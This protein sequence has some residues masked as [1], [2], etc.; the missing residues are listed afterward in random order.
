MGAFIHS[1]LAPSE[2]LGCHASRLCHHPACVVR[3][4]AHLRVLSP[5]AVGP[6][7]IRSRDPSANVTALSKP[8]RG[9]QNPSEG[10][11]RTLQRGGPEPFRG[12]DQS[13]ICTDAPHKAK[14]GR[15][16]F[17]GGSLR[18]ALEAST[19]AA[20]VALG[21]PLSPRPYHTVGLPQAEA[22][23]KPN[24]GGQH[25]DFKRNSLPRELLIAQTYNNTGY[26]WRLGRLVKG[27]SARRKSMEGRPSP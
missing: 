7:S 2:R 6:L 3:L 14:G 10:R 12:D 22:M 23:W 1:D 4:L 9:I 21:A 5:S 20:L 13:E 8:F 18:A 27:R 17:K 16:G 19:R 15:T 24:K 11:I 25:I 26:H